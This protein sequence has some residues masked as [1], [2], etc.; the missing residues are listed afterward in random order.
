MPTI[1]V[2]SPEV[3][4]R[5]RQELTRMGITVHRYRD[6]DTLWPGALSEAKGY[7]RALLNNEL[8]SLDAYKL[9]TQ[10]QT[11]VLEVALNTPKLSE[12][13]DRKAGAPNPNDLDLRFLESDR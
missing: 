4:E 12:G 10:E 6:D 8:I 1:E 7:M 13:A 9:L 2:D 11:K 3:L 5:A